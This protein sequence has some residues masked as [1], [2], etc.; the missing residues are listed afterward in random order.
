MKVGECV[1]FNIEFKSHYMQV[2]IKRNISDAD[3]R[4]RISQL[5]AINVYV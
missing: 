4:K 5:S 1:Y 3:E 2:C